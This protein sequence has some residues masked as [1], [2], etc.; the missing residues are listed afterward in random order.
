MIGAGTIPSFSFTDKDSI[1]GFTGFM[2]MPDTIIRSQNLI[3]QVNGVKAADAGEIII[4]DGVGNI[5][6]QLFFPVSLNNS[7]TIP[8]SSFS[9]LTSGFG[10]FRIN[11]S[12]YNDQILSGKG[13]RFISQLQLN[14]NLYIK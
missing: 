3:I 7:V 10:G 8:A 5:A 13:F 12:K 4:F 2:A 1:P 11:L 14:Y 9:T 6:S